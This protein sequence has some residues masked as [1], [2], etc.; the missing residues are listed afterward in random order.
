MT[1]Y[2]LQ[3]FCSLRYDLSCASVD[4]YG[5]RALSAKLKKYIDVCVCAHCTGKCL[6][7]ERNAS[8]R[9]TLTEIEFI[10]LQNAH[11]TCTQIQ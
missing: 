1:N 10:C 7:I 8:I 3:T 11:L 6:N 5:A 9:S 4:L 2:A